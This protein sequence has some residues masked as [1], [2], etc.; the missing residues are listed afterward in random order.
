MNK[1][2]Y[3]LTSVIAT[4]LMLLTV[5]LD[6]VAE[7]TDQKTFDAKLAGHAV[8]PAMTF[9]PAPA[10]APAAFQIS[11]RFTGPGNMRTDRLYSIEG[12]TWLAPAEAPRTTGQ[13]LP[14]VGQPVQ[15]F[16]GIKNVGNGEF[17]VLID[18]GFGSQ[19][20]SP[21]AMLMTHR[22][23]PDWQK[24][25]VEILDTIFLHDPDRVIPFRLVNEHTAKR[26][27]TGAD[28][29]IEGMQPIGDRIWFGDE[30]GPYIFAT[31]VTGRVVA[32]FETVV[33]GKIVRSPDNHSISLPSQPGPVSFELRRSRGFE[34]M[35]ASV[36]GKYLYPLFEGP[37]WDAAKQDWEAV[38]GREFLRIIEFNI[39]AQEFTGR[40]WKYLLETNGNNIGDFN[41]I[42]A[43][44][45]LVIERDNGEGDPR[46]GCPEAPRSDCFNKPALFK[47][48]YLIDF[49]AAQNDF[50]KKVGYVD[51]MTIA[52][53][54]GVALRGTID[55]RFTFPFVTIEDVDMVDE[56]HI[57]VGND[58]NLPFSTGRSIGQ[59][60]DNELIL[61][62]VGT[63]LTQP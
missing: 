38:D 59:A 46:L 21:D 52:D 58:N 9:V 17:M 20:N 40:Q 36:D 8:I 5:S 34:G 29:D 28:F 33:D 27:L 49:E 44:R 48:V 55:G 2:F 60:D 32:Y 43:T 41:M 7:G 50:V 37:L 51:L 61:L 23:R 11:G 13:Y 35:A 16:S 63:M 12:K 19:R 15:G 30:F 3:F 1:K 57:I 39:E 22:V 10:D 31:D 45:G 18:N 14:F 62:D 4:T 47:R 56:R 24:G 25:R 54:E 6:V 42:S 53:N 26:Y